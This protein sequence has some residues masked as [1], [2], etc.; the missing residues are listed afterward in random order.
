MSENTSGSGAD[1]G[2]I[3]P[4]AAVGSFADSISNFFP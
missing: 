2:S 4:F 1:L 3:N